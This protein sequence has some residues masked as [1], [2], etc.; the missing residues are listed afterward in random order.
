MEAIKTKQL[1]IVDEQGEP[2]I[3]MAMRGDTPVIGIGSG[4]MV[5][6]FQA[7]EDTASIRVINGKTPRLQIAATA[8]AAAMNF[9]NEKG[10]SAV[11]LASKADTGNTLELFNAKGK[12]R[13]GLVANDDVSAAFSVFNPNGQ[14]GARLGSQPKGGFKLTF[15]DA[16][17]KPISLIPE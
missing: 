17:G 2:R 1:T 8:D 3:V 11:N 12:I 5:M 10:E 14:L 4:Q 15:H 6:T 9:L 7:S 16:N 13:L